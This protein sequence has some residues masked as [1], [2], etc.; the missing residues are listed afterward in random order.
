MPRVIS[1]LQKCVEHKIQDCLIQ[2][3]HFNDLYVLLLSLDIA[4]I[5][6]QIKQ[7]NKTAMKKR[8]IEIHDISQ[9]EALKFLK[10]G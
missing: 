10:G 9:N 3:L 4:N 6:E 7:R 5:E 8:N 2:R 1:I